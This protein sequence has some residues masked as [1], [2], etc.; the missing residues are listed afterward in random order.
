MSASATTQPFASAHASTPQAR[1][2]PMPSSARSQRTTCAPWP[3]NSEASA[4]SCGR[5]TAITVGSAARIARSAA[6]PIGVPSGSGVRSLSPPKRRAAPAA[7]RMPVG[8]DA[9]HARALLRQQPEAPSRTT[10]GT[11]ARSSMPL[12]FCGV[13]VNTPCVPTTSREPSS[14]SRSAARNARCRASRSARRSGSRARAGASRPTRSRR[15]SPGLL[16]NFFSYA[17]M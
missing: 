7:S 1:L 16:P 15:T 17:S 9:G 6:T 4:S 14:A 8:R 10:T 5:T 11:R 3:A 2:A 12:W 13:I